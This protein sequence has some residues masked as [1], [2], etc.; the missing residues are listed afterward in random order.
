MFIKQNKVN[1]FLYVEFREH[2]I[3]NFKNKKG[4]LFDISA[5][6]FPTFTPDFT[7]DGHFNQHQYCVCLVNKTFAFSAIQLLRFLGYQSSQLLAPSQWLEDFSALLKLNQDNPLIKAH[8]NKLN[9]VRSIV[10]DKFK[11]L[12]GKNGP[13]LKI[14]FSADFHEDKRFCIISLKEEVKAKKDLDAKR[15]LL[16]RRR[17]DYLQEVAADESANFIKAI[18]ME[19]TFWEETK[20]FNHKEKKSKRIIF[21]ESAK[22]LANIFRQFKEIKNKDGDLVFE[23]SVSDYSRLIVSNFSRVG[24]EL[25]IESSIR[26]YLSDYNIKKGSNEAKGL[27]TNFNLE[28]D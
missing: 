17:T 9:L 15:F 23:G 20:T 19:L 2:P 24:G 22:E 8:Q 10:L 21:K 3:V 1:G 11:Q 25:F 16:L 4:T 12:T 13:D 14:I 28:K 18:D 26:R 5:E 27:D 7:K 6:E